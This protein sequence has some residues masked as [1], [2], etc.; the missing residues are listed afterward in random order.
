MDSTGVNVV[1]DSGFPILDVLLPQIGVFIIIPLLVM[2]K[3]F[4]F[5]KILPT[6]TWCVI[7][8][9]GTVF[10]LRHFLMPEI[11]GLAAMQIGFALTGTT[12][13]AHRT[14]EKTKK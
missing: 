7:L 12:L 11:S 3:K 5:S 1:I 6:P 8:C 9:Q 10:G 14:I 13:V 4:G 2:F